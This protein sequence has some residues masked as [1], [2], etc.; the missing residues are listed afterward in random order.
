MCAQRKSQVR[1]QGGGIIY[2]PRREAS[3]ET[4]PANTLTLDYQPPEL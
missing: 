3:G 4:N 2:K 1:T